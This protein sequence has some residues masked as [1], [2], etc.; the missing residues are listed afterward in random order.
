MKAFIFLSLISA[1]IFTSAA[2]QAA[3]ESPAACLPGAKDWIY[4]N[5]SANSSQAA[6]QA[7]TFCAQGGKVSCLDEAKSW[8]YSK[9]SANNSQAAER[10]LQFCRGGDVAC[11]EPTRDWVYK[12]TSA[13]ATQAAEKAVEICR[14]AIKCEST[15][16]DKFP[17]R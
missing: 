15:R 11:L 16:P 4:K 6:D 12:N 5:T 7:M 8:L 2:S 10:A 14:G 13:N 9:T 3:F 1:S 17:A